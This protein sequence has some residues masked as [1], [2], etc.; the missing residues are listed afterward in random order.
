[1][2]DFNL[3]NS[4]IEENQSFYERSYE[5]EIDPS[6]FD[7]Q[8]MVDLFLEEPLILEEHFLVIY[9]QQ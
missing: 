4:D 6:I 2:S 1:M 8:E 9:Q 5:F 7:D 3:I